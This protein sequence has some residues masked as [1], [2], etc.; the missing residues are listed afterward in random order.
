MSKPKREK[1]TATV[2]PEKTRP[3]KPLVELSKDQL[4]AIAPGQPSFLIPSGKRPIHC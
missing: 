2:T 1:L 4:E 3:E